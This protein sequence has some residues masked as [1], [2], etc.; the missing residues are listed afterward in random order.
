MRELSYTVPFTLYC[1]DAVTAVA[2]SK[3][4]KYRGRSLKVPASNKTNSK[5]NGKRGSG[6]LCTVADSSYRYFE[7]FSGVQPLF[8]VVQ[9]VSLA[10]QMASGVV[11]IPFIPA[12]LVFTVIYIASMS[13][14]LSDIIAQP[15]NIPAQTTSII[16][17]L[18]FMSAHFRF[19]FS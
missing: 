19:I 17:Q 13:V 12:P 14:Y 11:Q 9:P 1:A 8:V 5:S 6:G 18:A 2:S 16:V 10:L 15:V 7:G 3:R 4:G